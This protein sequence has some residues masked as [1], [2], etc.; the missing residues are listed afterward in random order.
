MNEFNKTDRY[1]IDLSAEFEGLIPA[2]DKKT[3]AKLVGKS[4]I[5]PNFMGTN[6][7]GPQSL[8]C[9]DIMSFYETSGGGGDDEKPQSGQTEQ[10]IIDEIIES[11]ST[12]DPVVVDVPEGQTVN[13]LNIPAGTTSP[14]TINGEFANNASVNNPNETPITLN[15]TSDEP[16]NINVSSNGTI[17]MSGEY[18]NVTIDGSGISTPENSQPAQIHGDVIIQDGN[19]SASITA[20]FVGDDEQ[21]VTF[22]GTELEV[23]NTDNTEESNIVVT[24]PNATVTMGGVY[25]EVEVTCGEDTLILKAGFHAHRLTVNKGNVLI[26]GDS[27]TEFADEFIATGTVTPIMD[28]GATE[29]FILEAIAS[30]TGTSVQIELEEGMVVR[31]LVIPSDTN[32][33]P[34]IH[35]AFANGAI[36]TFDGPTGKFITLN[37]SSETPTDINVK[38]NGTIYLA[39]NYNNVNIDGKGFSVSSGNYPSVHGNVNITDTVSAVTVSGKFEGSERQ[40]INYN[41]AKIT[42]SNSSTEGASN[43]LVNTPNAA[44]TMGGTYNKVEETGTLLTLNSGFFTNT[45]VANSDVILNGVDINDFATNST[46]TGTIR[47]VQYNKLTCSPGESTL[48]EDTLSNNLAFGTFASG[49]SKWNLNNFTYTNKRDNTPIVLLRNKPIL[50]IYGP[51]KMTTTV[52]NDG[53]GLWV[54]GEN[55]VLNIHSGDYEGYV[56]CLYAEQGT[57]NVYGGTF[58]LLDAATADRDSNNN[59]KFLVNCLDASY[60]AGTAHINIYGGK[61]YEYNPAVSY[62]EPNGPVSFVAPGYH[63]VESTEDGVKVY[64]V[65]AD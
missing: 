36:V 14:V 57:I 19:D 48:M 18:D 59:L 11:G 55:A 64:E 6:A 34:K 30:A 40:E 3:G 44:I 16:K 9:V 42:V 38:A 41:G 49:K 28:S 2:A 54:S 50:D 15:N 62:S 35:G 61:F 33:S 63:V 1:D 12:G 10:D 60:A 23:E 7:L 27:I 47:P 58:K 22:N 53:Y 45:L 39:G 46:C 24:A 25:D 65:V 21:E 43:V 37:N 32:C 4:K 51:G 26:H 13:D 52:T 8:T 29:Q 56:H 20:G 5:S 31:N 17:N